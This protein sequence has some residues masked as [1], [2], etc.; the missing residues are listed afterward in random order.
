MS[1]L[2]AVRRLSAGQD[3][4]RTATVQEMDRM[5]SALAGEIRFHV[6]RNCCRE[7]A[8]VAAA[9]EAM[10]E[11]ADF[12]DAESMRMHVTAFAAGI[13]GVLRRIGI[14]REAIR[15]GIDLFNQEQHECVRV[16]LP[17]ESPFPDA[18]AGTIVRV[19]EHGYNVEG[20]LAKAARVWVQTEE[21]KESEGERGEQ[22]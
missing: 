11:S 9:L 17:G 22:E 15:V 4:L 19:E 2:E 12:S 6:L 21:Q 14:E 7:L 8:P 16:C 5:R 3:A 20:K 1:L 10:A 18:V 13:E